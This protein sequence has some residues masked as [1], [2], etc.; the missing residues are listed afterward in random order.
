ML[1]LIHSHDLE[2]DLECSTCSDIPWSMTRP[3]TSHGKFQ[4][5][6]ELT[7]SNTD[8]PEKPTVAQL[9]KIFFARYGTDTLPYPEPRSNTRS[10]VTFR[11]HTLVSY[12]DGLLVPQIKPTTVGSPLFGYPRLHIQFIRTYPTYFY[13]QPKDVS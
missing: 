8:P 12:S 2:T 3:T 6:A 11:N 10:Y 1:S 9:V 7:T 5:S 13:P 4:Q